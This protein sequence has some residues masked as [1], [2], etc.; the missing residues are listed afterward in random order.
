[1]NYIQ[2]NPVIA[3]P[4]Q[5]D[6]LPN[7]GLGEV[8]PTG[9][10]QHDTPEDQ[11]NVAT[12]NGSPS[13]S[14]VVVTE[15]GP[16]EQ[17]QHR[18]VPSNNALAPSFTNPDALLNNVVG[19]QG[20]QSAMRSA[21]VRATFRN[22]APLKPVKNLTDGMA[23]RQSVSATFSDVSPANHPASGFQPLLPNLTTGNQ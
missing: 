18:R 3:R 11:N 17:H 7:A 19:P 8:V 21:E 16:V 22:D 1:M 14:N 20:R 23:D 10:V 9:F 15:T 13:F 2:R 12:T 4:I 6:T 5:N